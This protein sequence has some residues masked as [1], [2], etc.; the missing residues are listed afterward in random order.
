MEL[1]LPVIF[2]LVLAGLAALAFIA[3][4]MLFSRR[5]Q[6]WLQQQTRV[7]QQTIDQLNNQL[8]LNLDGNTQLIQ[9]QIEGMTK[10]VGDRLIHTSKV[11]NDANQQIH[12][13]L[14]HAAKLF[15]ELQNKLG[16]FEEANQRIYEVGKDIASLQEI[17]KQPKAR[18]SLGEFFL[19]DLLA[20]MLPRERF[21]LQYRFANNEVVDA[22]IRL[23]NHI[24]SIDSKFPLDNFRRFLECPD[25]AQKMALKKNF[26][27][28]TRRHIDAVSKKYIQPAE[29]TFDFALMYVMAENVFYELLIREEGQEVSLQE[30]A[31]KKRV[32]LVS[33]NSFYAYLGALTQALRGERMQQE[34]RE[35]AAGLSHLVIEIE[36]FRGDFDKIG[37]H[38]GHLKTSYEVA[39]KRLNRYEDRLERLHS[40]DQAEVE[41]KPPIKLIVE[42]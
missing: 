29:H 24:L 37:F 1:S 18:G 31:L 12:T 3:V 42:S 5:E 19:A 32:I 27:S 26:L 6:D 30:Y 10:D 4:R 2:L 40:F 35:F 22:I 33:P 39:E 16:K 38:L 8:R 34:I 25:E 14:D 20:E 41:R 28:D 17:L 13:R 36:K 7:L 11:S 9:R 21:E 15:S 23:G